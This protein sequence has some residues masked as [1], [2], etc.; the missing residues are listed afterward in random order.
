MMSENVKC[1]RAKPAHT[2]LLG[3]VPQWF[4][5][6]QVPGPW[7]SGLS[8]STFAELK[9]LREVRDVLDRHQ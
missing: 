2:A 5:R 3:T 8:A 7:R 6:A 1:W 4:N 9:V